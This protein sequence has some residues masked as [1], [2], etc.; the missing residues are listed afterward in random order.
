[1]VLHNTLRFTDLKR[2]S[3]KFVSQQRQ[4]DVRHFG[5][6]V[7]HG[8]DWICKPWIG[9]GKDGFEK[10]RFVETKWQC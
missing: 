1:M 9:F 6:I 5:H 4:P 8:L 7:N 3:R 2:T 10:H